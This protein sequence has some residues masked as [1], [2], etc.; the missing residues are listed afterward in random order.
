[1]VGMRIDML[2]TG[3]TYRD[4]KCLDVSC[5]ILNAVDF[6]CPVQLEAV[7]SIKKAVTSCYFLEYSARKLK[8]L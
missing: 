1:M 4:D 2:P 8:Y 7:T 6:S 5:L 3:I